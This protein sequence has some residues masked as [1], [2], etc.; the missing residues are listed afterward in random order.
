[1]FRGMSLS[2]TDLAAIL[3]DGLLVEKTK[4]PTREIFASTEMA[5]PMYYALSRITEQN[6]LAVIVVIKPTE[7][8]DFQANTNG[9]YV[10]TKANI[11]LEAIERVFVFDPGKSSSPFP[12][13]ELI[14]S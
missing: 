9:P 14:L 4:G 2:S 6:N 13:R 10:K 8:I 7:N 5:S 11:P 12:F 1:M 3:R